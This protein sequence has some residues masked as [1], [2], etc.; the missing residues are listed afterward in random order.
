MRIAIWLLALI[1]QRLPVSVT[2]AVWAGVGTAAIAVIGVL[3]LGES[4]DAAKVIG[5]ALIVAGV[6]LL[7]L[8]G[9]H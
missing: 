7:N 6:V 8:H 2:Y 4:W 9:A 3:F 1:V 5:I